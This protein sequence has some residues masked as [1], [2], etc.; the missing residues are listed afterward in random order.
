MTS[1]KD[2]IM[3]T[4]A[5]KVFLYNKP[6]EICKDVSGRDLDY[7]KMTEEEYIAAYKKDIEDEI[8]SH[9]LIFR[10]AG[11]D[12]IMPLMEFIASR[13]RIDLVDEVSPYDIYRFIEFGYGLVVENPERKIKGCLFEVGYQTP[14]LASYSVRLGIAKSLKGKNLGKLLTVYTCLLAMERGSLVKKGLIDFDNYANLY[15]QL[16]K[17][18]WMADGFYPELKGLGSC[19]TVSLPLTSKGML[20]NS[21]DNNKLLTYIETH[22][23]GRDYLLLD[24]EDVKSM[25]DA[26]QSGNFKVVALIKG[27]TLKETHQFMLMH[28]DVLHY[29]PINIRTM[30]KYQEMFKR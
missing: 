10:L 28:A 15:I 3:T 7:L 29:A 22:E 30:T 5:P 14:D 2:N 20:T 18:G 23:A 27:G 6:A 13:Y 24:I 19:F 26:Y 11:F 17:N 25:T 21:I 16:N 4:N 1:K 8:R 9:D 12:D